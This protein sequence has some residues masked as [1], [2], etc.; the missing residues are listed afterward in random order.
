M[1]DGPGCDPAG[2]GRTLV[3][4]APA[5]LDAVVHAACGLS[6]RLV[7]RLIA[8]GAVRVNG[9][10]AAKGDRVLPGDRVTLPAAAA[11]APEP[12]LGLAVLHEDAGI[13]A[14]EKPGGMPSHA[15]D[16]R[17][18]GTAAAFVLAR[19]P[20][21]AAVGDPLAPG[22]VHRLDTGTSGILLVARTPALFS[23]VRAA[24]AARRVEK[25]YLA[26]VHGRPPARTTVRSPLAHDPAD[27]R[28]MRPARP[29]ERAW[30]AETRLETLSAGGG[31]ALVAATIRTG[32]T[33]QVRAHLAALG[34][35]VLGDRI[36]GGPDAC[37]PASRHAL[38]AS[39]ILLEAAGLPGLALESPLPAD[40]AALSVHAGG[41]PPSCVRDGEPAASARQQP[42]GR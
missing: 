15:L 17:E 42:H 5:R 26:L 27:R 30:A 23:I 18:R 36:Y 6:R 12:E 40:L 3:V 24:F 13:A 11:L 4:E 14:V 25:R 28:R 16:P 2:A 34:C 32:V 33:H 8:D 10:R 29:G 7:H 22:L 35:P 20:E 21:T 9:R 37:L 19:W 1:P 39:A 38:H 31:V 41:A